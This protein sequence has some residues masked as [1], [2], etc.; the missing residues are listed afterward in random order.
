MF[1]LRMR[2]YML[3][4]MLIYPFPNSTP[5]ATMSFVLHH[6]LEL[7]AVASMPNGHRK[8]SH[9]ELEGRVYGDQVGQNRCGVDTARRSSVGDG[10]GEGLTEP[11]R[12]YGDHG[13]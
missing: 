4:R 8:S 6:S 11:D 3:V 1:D 5:T 13:I 7:I 2:T 9:T 12:K 10:R